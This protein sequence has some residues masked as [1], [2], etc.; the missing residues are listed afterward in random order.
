MQKLRGTGTTF[1]T[2]G[3]AWVPWHGNHRIAMQNAKRHRL[4]KAGLTGGQSKDE[5]RALADAAAATHS[6]RRIP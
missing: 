5:L 2:S 6:I 4:V 3:K 1:S